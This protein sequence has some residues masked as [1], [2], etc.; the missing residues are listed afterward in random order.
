MKSAFLPLY[1]YELCITEPNR[2]IPLP[3]VFLEV[4][5]ARPPSRWRSVRL[6]PAARQPKGTFGKVLRWQAWAWI[7]LQSMLD[8]S[9]APETFCL[10]GRS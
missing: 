3:H 7:P 5:H 10:P 2:A 8:S 4:S 6:N 1:Y 9:V